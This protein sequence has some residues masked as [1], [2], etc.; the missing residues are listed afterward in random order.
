MSNP[1]DEQEGEKELLEGESSSEFPTASFPE[2]ESLGGFMQVYKKLKLMV[3]GDPISLNSSKQKNQ[4]LNNFINGPGAE[5]EL[6]SH[7]VN[8]DKL[9]NERFSK[10]ILSIWRTTGEAAKEDNQDK[11]TN[12]YDIKAAKK[13]EPK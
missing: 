8:L 2:G 4:E 9:D 5:Q 7:E 13:N 3:T 6:N 12:I 11:L 10:S 1:P